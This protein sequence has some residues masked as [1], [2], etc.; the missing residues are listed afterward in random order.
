[1]RALKDARWVGGRGLVSN[2]CGQVECLGFV[3]VLFG[4]CF[5]LAFDMH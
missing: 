3:T 5:A 1:M 4:F 2:V